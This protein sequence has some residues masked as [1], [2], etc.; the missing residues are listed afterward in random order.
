MENGGSS[1]R[2]FERD[3]NGKTHFTTGSSHCSP[4]DTGNFR[5]RGCDYARCLKYVL[6]NLKTDELEGVTGAY[7][8]EV[9]GILKD[10]LSALNSGNQENRDW[11]LGKLRR[12]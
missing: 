4:I 10:L 2:A 11:R 8:D 12:V 1:R 3:E 7:Q 6:K 9:E 5:R